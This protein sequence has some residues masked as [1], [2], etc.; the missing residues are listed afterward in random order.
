VVGVALALAACATPQTDAVLEAPGALPPRAEA[1]GTPFHAQR[2][3][4]CG[5][6]SLAMALNWSGVPVG[7]DELVE[8]VYT[9][10]RGGSLANDLVS[11][12]RRHGRLA[13]PVRN[14][15][16][17]MAELAAGRPVIVL[18]NLALPW[19]PQWHYAVA[20]G[21]DL[22]SETL[23]LHSGTTPRMPLSLATFEL[24]W[25]RG[26]H[27]ALVVLPPGE[28]PAA[29]DRARYFAAVA[30]LEGAGAAEGAAMAY[31]AGLEA[32]PGDLG[33][34]MGLGNALYRLDRKDEAAQAFRAAARA[35]PDSGDAHNNLAHT[36]M[37]RGELADA[38]EMARRAVAIG[39]ANLPTYRKTLEAIERALASRQSARAVR[40]GRGAGLP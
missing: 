8:Q 10:E 36:L 14:L 30:A 40:D 34:Q 7:P 12:A 11:G 28:L 35:H 16:E 39:G 4:E 38:R 19:I 33:L 29:R 26:K 25:E 27:W 23:I 3:M 17:L 32:W 20:I 31:S 21:Y 13:Y 9:P 1:A 6:A 2:T 24:T 15:R 18:Q 22:P 37:E 5:P